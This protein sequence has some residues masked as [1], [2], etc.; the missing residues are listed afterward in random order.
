MF[1]LF[2]VDRTGFISVENMK[3]VLEQIGEEEEE[4]ELMVKRA[5][6]DAD[7]YVKL[8]DFM[9]VMRLNV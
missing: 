4:V 3:A 6:L 7:G 9:R 1:Q 5:D 8:E 2:D